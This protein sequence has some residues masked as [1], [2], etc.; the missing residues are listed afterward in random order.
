M[1][2]LARKNV[3]LREHIKKLEAR[4][5]K[6]LEDRLR[7]RSAGAVAGAGGTSGTYQHGGAHTEPHVPS[8]ATVRRLS[9]SHDFAEKTRLLIHLEEQLRNLHDRQRGSFHPEMSEAS[10]LAD[11]KQ[12]V[13]K[14]ETLL[15][16]KRMHDKHHR[17]LAAGAR[18]HWSNIS[19]I[20]DDL[21]MRSSLEDIASSL[22]KAMMLDELATTCE[23]NPAIDAAVPRLDM[24]SPLREVSEAAQKATMVADLQ[25]FEKGAVLLRAVDMSSDLAD[26][27]EVWHAARRDHKTW[28]SFPECRGCKRRFAGATFIRD[29]PHVKLVREGHSYYGTH[30]SLHMCEDCGK[31]WE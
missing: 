1:A 6:A 21:T 29:N 3:L 19:Y 26:V 7:A 14:A 25:L 30:P 4:E 10:T 18:S 9:A 20:D 27:S 31:Y 15:K 5:L 17:N 8:V 2:A 23:A 12:A 11:I 22:E 24:K 28:M 13:T 16:L